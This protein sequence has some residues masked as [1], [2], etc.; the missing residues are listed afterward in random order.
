MFEEAIFF[1]EKYK[2]KLSGVAIFLNALEK[3]NVFF[4]NNEMFKD[5]MYH[6]SIDNMK[7][8]VFSYKENQ[9]YEAPIPYIFGYVSR[10]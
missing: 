3:I 10:C 5:I 4:V 6:T 9:P 1:E 7:W 8:L 2:D